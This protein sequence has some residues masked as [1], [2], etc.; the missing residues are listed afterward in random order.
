MKLQRVAILLLVLSLT[1]GFE[2]VMLDRFTS[3][4]ISIDQPVST[5][6]PSSDVQASDVPAQTPV[7]TFVAVPTMPGFT[8]PPLGGGSSGGGGGGSSSNSGGSSSNNNNSS[9]N[10]SSSSKPTAKPTAKPTN[11][12]PPTEKPG[13]SV[14]SGSFSSNTGTNLNMNVSWEAREQG[15]GKCRVYITGTINSYSISV[16]SHPVS[17]SFGGYSTSTMGKSLN[18]SNNGSMTSSSLFSTYIDV[19]SGTSGTMSV[20][21]RFGGTY[22]DVEITDVEASGN[23]YTD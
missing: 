6:V 17:I 23:V 5:P 7:P 20:S 10:N 22:N 8:S 3:E 16:A 19:P 1:V 4:E 11:P 18:V 21:W 15:S 9:N 13:T 2:A 14:G 12:P